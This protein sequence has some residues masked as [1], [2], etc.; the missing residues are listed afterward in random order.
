MTKTPADQDLL[1]L[2]S[3]NFDRNLP[4]GRPRRPRHYGAHEQ[5]PRGAS[6]LWG[7]AVIGLTFLAIGL[8]WLAFSIFVGRKLPRWIGIRNP[9]GQWAV[10]VAVVAVLL[11]GPFGG[12]HRGD[13]AV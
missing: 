7:V 10:T 12:S 6:N 1:T 11:V 3:R 4:S 9:A 13:A 8:L 2:S 5:G